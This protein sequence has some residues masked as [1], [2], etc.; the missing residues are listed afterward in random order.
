MDYSQKKT[1]ANKMYFL[2]FHGQ[3]NPNTRESEIGGAYINCWIEANTEDQADQI[4]RTKISEASWTIIDRE[5]CYEIK[6]SDYFNK[7]QGLN[8]FE[9][10]LI[11]KWVLVFHT[12]P[13]EENSDENDT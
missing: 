5:E 1:T 13:I 12:Y 2:T 3:P 8:Y 10:A 11:D 6:R 4:A 9:Q 7:P